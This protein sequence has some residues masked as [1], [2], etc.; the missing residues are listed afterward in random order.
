M[1]MNS[2]GK[3]SIVALGAIVLLG[4]AP[5]VLADGAPY[6]STA[7]YS[8]LSQS[9]VTLNGL[10]NPN[11]LSTTAWF[12]YGTSNSLGQ[13]GSTFLTGNVSYQTSFS[14]SI[15]NL[16]SNSTYYY[17]IF[18]KNAYGTSQG[19][20]SSF[21][22]SNSYYNQPTSNYPIVTTSSATLLSSNS[23]TFY[24]SVNPN[25]SYTTT[26]F[27]YGPTSSLGNASQSTSISS[28]SSYVNTSANAFNLN[29][30]NTYYYRAVAQNSFG[31]AY[32]SILSIY[33]GNSNNNTQV[34]NNQDLSGLSDSLSKLNSALSGFEKNADNSN[35]AT[36][37]K[38]TVE[39]VTQASS[40]GN[41]SAKLI[42]TSDKSTL[43]SGDTFVI[44]AEINAIKDLNKIGLQI[45]L[46]P[47]LV[48]D[49]SADSA[50]SKNG[51]TITFDIS[52]IA[53][54]GVQII[55]LNVHLSKDADN[56]KVTK[57]TTTG[58]LNFSDST[59]K[60][61]IPLLTSLDV[62]V[63]GQGL[64]ASVSGALSWSSGLTIFL[65]IA[66]ILLM[67]VATKR[68]MV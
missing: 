10:V 57:V 3:L 39:K 62:K 68:L 44:T 52:D 65:I 32:G 11:G 67:A 2:I 61:S 53:A 49:S 1:K 42:L 15:S 58:A 31:N 63:G 41:D 7:S 27:E 29:S 34:T 28:N 13:T 21:S 43:K 4:L 46:D 19:S 33:T 51:N 50:F 5:A 25:N 6:V 18:A 38:T 30:N 12:E 24:G 16:N 35:P 40:I 60:D 14:S 64:F 59:G 26:W 20:I 54:K 48:F 66:L 23:V 17:R 36:D 22:T 45:N 9:S 56:S 55:K 8:N 37:K 47:S